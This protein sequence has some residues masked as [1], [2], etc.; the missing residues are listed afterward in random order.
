MR[1]NKLNKLKRYLICFFI[2]HKCVPT[3]RHAYLIHEHYCLTCDRLYISHTEYGG[4][5]L[6]AD[7][8]SDRI[9]RDREEAEEKFK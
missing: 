8:D 3:G 4:M 7:K 9:F 2:G 5:L 6:P 1:N